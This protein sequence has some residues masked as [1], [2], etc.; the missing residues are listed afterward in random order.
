MDRPAIDVPR[1][2]ASLAARWARADVVAQTASTNTD[3]LDDP[4]S[5]DGRVLVAEFQSAGRGR[6]DRA[7]TS[8]PRAGLT[9]SVLLRPPTPMPTWGWLPLLAGVAIREG[10][11]AVTGVDT[12]LKWPNDLLAGPQRKKIAG[13]LAQTAAPACVI[14]CGLNVTTTA[15]EL[16][17]E[18]ASSLGL[19][20]AG[21]LDRTDVLVAVLDRLD[22]WLQRWYEVRGDAEAAGLL[23][24]YRAACATLGQDVLVRGI[25]GGV[26]RGTAVDIDRDGRLRVDT[27]TGQRVV[28]AGDVEHV[29]AE[30]RHG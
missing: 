25:D 1:L 12:A 8:P 5:P 20:G 22:G 10:V 13:I 27:S 23:A 15:D 30:I 29:R 28:G 16:P 6:L 7:W 9:F 19:C 26:L 24:A 21:N 14:G 2:R 11:T 18:Q 4:A 17:T 3:L